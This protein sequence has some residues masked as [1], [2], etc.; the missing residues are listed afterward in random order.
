MKK[1]IRTFLTDEEE[2]VM[3]MRFS[4]LTIEQIA[5]ILNKSPAAIK[6]TEKRAWTNLN[7]SYVTITH[8]DR[9]VASGESMK[10]ITKRQERHSLADVM[11]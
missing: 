11:I 6:K 4:E 9:I 8:W 3:T 1:H 7:R 2:A 5:V 10:N